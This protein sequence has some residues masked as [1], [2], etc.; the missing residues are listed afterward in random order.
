MNLQFRWVYAFTL[1]RE[2]SA[3]PE[4]LIEGETTYLE[5]EKVYARRFGPEHPETVVLR[6]E[7]ARMYSELADRQADK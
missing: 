3:T 6:D 4:D 2:S 5:L 7:I 1:W